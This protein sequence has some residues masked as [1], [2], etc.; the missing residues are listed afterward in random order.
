MILKAKSHEEIFGCFDNSG[1]KDAIRRNYSI[2]LKVNLARPAESG[3]PRT[4]PALLAE[5]IQYTAQYNGRCTIGEGANGYL[6][7][8]LDQAGLSEIM[9]NYGVG[10]IDLD[11][12]N[13]DKVVVNGE[14]HFLPKCLK[15][16]GCRI[17]IPAAS[18]RPGMVF[19]NNVKLFVGIVPRRM[20]QSGDAVVSWR[21]RMHVDLHKSVANLYR[22]V[23]EYSPFE[24]YINGGLAMDEQKG[25]FIMGD[26]LVGNDAVELDL[27]VL[28]NIFPQ[29]AVP[30]Y[31]ESLKMP[32]F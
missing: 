21:P 13:V 30:Q 25:E 15:N 3:H 29:H 28:Q 8:N 9:K 12:E 2:F 23:Q 22:A 20:Y 17:A 24:F 16:F 26:I 7:A 19:S 11:E 10:V 32:N 31:L 5:I 6:Q 4:D 1:L 14:E 18:K 27:Y